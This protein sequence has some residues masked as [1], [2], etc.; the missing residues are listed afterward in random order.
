MVGEIFARE[1]IDIS[2]KNDLTTKKNLVIG[3]EGRL[4]Q[5]FMNLLTNAR[6]AT[7]EQ[8]DR[9]IDLRLWEGKE[10]YYISVKDNGKGIPEDIIGRIFDPFFTTKEVN[11]GTGIGL[12]LVHSI[13]MEH[14]GNIDATNLPDG[15][16]Q[17]LLSLPKAIK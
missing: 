6:D 14:K 10:S 17:F 2:F 1:G 3:N 8:E 11:K 15:G 7:E 13:V 12:S 5:V 4:Q 9:K 16:C